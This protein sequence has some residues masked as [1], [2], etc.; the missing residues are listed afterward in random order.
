MPAQEPDS[1]E[2]NVSSSEVPRRE[3]RHKLQII[4]A[5]LVAPAGVCEFVAFLLSHSEE[6][7]SVDSE[8]VSVMTTKDAK[9][10]QDV[11]HLGGFVLG[12]LAFPK[13]AAALK[14]GDTEALSGFFHPEF[15]GKKFLA[16][17]VARPRCIPLPIFT[18]STRMPTIANRAI[19]SDL[20]RRCWSTD[21]NSA[22]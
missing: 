2:I 6:T 9:Y 12:D 21:R 16:T 20:S 17:T 15:T 3:S 4:V 19:V 1:D 8:S 11:E 14:A 10:L 22:A 5:G 13:I 7:I 18:T